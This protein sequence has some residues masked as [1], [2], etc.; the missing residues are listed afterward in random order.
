M[1]RLRA[2]S[3]NDKV[4]TLNSVEDQQRLPGRYG[5]AWARGAG[6]SFVYPACAFACAVLAASPANAQIPFPGT[7]RATEFERAG[8]DGERP[9]EVRADNTKAY[10]PFVRQPLPEGPAVRRE[11]PVAVVGFD[12]VVNPG[13]GEFVIESVQRA[14]EEQAQ[15]LLIE[16]NTPGG[17]VSS[18]EKIVQALLA[19]QIPVV[20][21]V[22]PSGAHAASAGTFITLAAH[23]AAMAPATR[24][25][26]AHPVT[27]TG[28]DPEAGGR[29]H[30][31]AKVEN[32]LLALVAGIARA[33]NRNAEWARDA[34]K[35]SVSAHAERALEIGVVDLVA[36]G[37]AGLFEALEGHELMLGER[38]VSLHPVGKPLV[39]Y[40]PSMRNKMLNLLANPGIAALLGLLGLIGI[41]IELYNPGLIVPG[42]VGVVCIL[43]S[44]IAVEQ[45]P[46]DVGAVILVVAGLGM[47]IAEIYTP[48]FGVLG[49]VGAFG[50]TVGLVLLV[51]I[52]DPDF[53]IDPSFRL[54]VWDVLPLTV[55]FLGFVGYVAVFV[56]QAKRRRSITGHD[57]L[58]GSTGRVLR[59]VGPESGQVFVEGEYWQARSP[60]TLDPNTEV[61][62]VEA[63]GLTLE[64]RR[65]NDDIT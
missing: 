25:G 32:D 44:L 17:L 30:L 6:V 52:G 61:E 63:D 42:V 57:G 20:V 1:H 50:L 48:T 28:A 19:A 21:Y 27:G 39:E 49:L 34:V 16:L 4:A 31:A 8:A 46:I 18:T 38:K 13:M 29:K 7:P 40:E 37:R 47:I 12:G 56:A 26:A 9:D 53:A 36:A 24:I 43:C 64:V 45:L 14:T 3:G 5:T 22:T 65:I 11:G 41:M 2:S 60:D 35:H 15:F 62:V 58:V 54:S 33:R 55:L 51:D 59:T 23:V 10:P